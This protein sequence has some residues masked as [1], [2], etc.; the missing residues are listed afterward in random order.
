MLGIQIGQPG[1]VPSPPIVILYGP[2]A[3]SAQSVDVT[4]PNI[5]MCQLGSLY[6]DFQTPGLYFK[7]GVA[8]A[9]NPNGQW[10]QVS[11]P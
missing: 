3:P 11:I 10:T 1:P 6:I 8:N 2:G 9:S 4:Q 5:R 7:T